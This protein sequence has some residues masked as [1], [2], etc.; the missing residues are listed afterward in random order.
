MPSVA[1]LE[2]YMAKSLEELRK[3]AEIKD[4]GKKD[5]E[6]YLNWFCLLFY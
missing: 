4:F 6:R 1:K 3:K 2:L 5:F